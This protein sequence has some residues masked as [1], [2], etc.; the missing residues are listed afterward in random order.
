MSLLSKGFVLKIAE[1]REISSICSMPSRNFSEAAAQFI[2]TRCA[3]PVSNFRLFAAIGASD[4]RH[5]NYFGG[6]LF[7][8]SFSRKVISSPVSLETECRT[9]V[10][11]GIQFSLI[12]V[13]PRLDCGARNQVLLTTDVGEYRGLEEFEHQ[14]TER[15]LS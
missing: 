7:E 12:S 8:M 5:L 13:K 11:G 9:V 3:A 2:T 14:L 6:T 1:K 15:R 10:D 4:A